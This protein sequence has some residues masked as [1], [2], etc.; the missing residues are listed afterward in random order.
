M[1]KFYL[2]VVLAVILPVVYCA[3]CE[4]SGQILSGCA[5]PCPRTCENPSPICIALCVFGCMC[6]SGEVVDTAAGKCVAQELC[7]PRGKCKIDVFLSIPFLYFFGVM[8]YVTKPEFLFLIMTF[9]FK[10]YTTSFN[11]RFEK[12]Y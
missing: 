6:P 8:K 3:D 11:L 7:P 1:A 12:D 10:L 4:I 5:S 9:I 2:T